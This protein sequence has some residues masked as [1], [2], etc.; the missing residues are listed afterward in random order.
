MVNGKHT[1]LPLNDVA[2]GT[3][4][5]SARLENVARYQRSC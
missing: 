2:V 5:R 3:V 1:N 4:T